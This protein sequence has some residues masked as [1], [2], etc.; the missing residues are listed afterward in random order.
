MKKFDE[1]I[2]L[3]N[4][5]L[6]KEI[7]NLRNMNTKLNAE[8]K[9]LK[10]ELQQS[11]AEIEQVKAYFM[12]SH[13]W[14][15]TAPLRGMRHYVRRGNIF[16]LLRFIYLH[17]PVNDQKKLWLKD[18]FYRKFGFL[19]KKQLR[20]RIWLAGNNGGDNA[21]SANFKLQRHFTGMMKGQ[22]G[23][24]AIHIHLY[25]TDLLEEFCDYLS[26]MPYKYD[27]LVSV[28]NKTPQQIDGLK[29]CFFRLSNVEKC[30]IRNLANQGRDVAPFFV[31]FKDLLLNYDYVAHIHTK[32]S[33]YTGSE[34]VEW[35]NYLLDQLIG[36]TENIEKIF[37]EFNINPDLGIV[38]PKPAP[39]VPYL[40]FTWLEN[41]ELGL[42]TLARLGIDS[43]KKTYFDYSAGTMF[44]ARPSALKKLINNLRQSDFPIEAG[45]TD[46][47]IAHVIERIICMVVNSEGMDYYETDFSTNSYTVN[48]GCKNLWQYLGKSMNDVKPYIDSHEFISFDIFDTLIM[49]NIAKP[50]FVNDIIERRIKNEL[51][52][53]IEFK[54]IRLLAEQN[55]R[56][57]HQGM[58]YDPSLTHIY[59]EFSRI[60]NFSVQIVN[61]LKKLELQVEMEL[62]IP[63]K[64]MVKWLD[65]AIEKK[66]KIFL[67]SDMYLEREN[68][69]ELLR[70]CGIKEIFNDDVQL[71]VSSE[72]GMRKDDKSVWNYLESMIDKQSLGHI[73]DNER[74]DWQIPIDMGFDSY[75][76]MSAYDAFSCC[77]FGQD[78]LDN[79][80]LTTFDAILL[81]P[82]LA[83]K[84]NSPFI[85]HDEQYF[86]KDFH[87]LGY[88]FYGP[89]LCIYILWLIKNFLSKDYQCIL[90]FARDGYFL[91]TL[92]KKVCKLLGLDE[93]NSKY[94]LTSRRAV[95]VA[96]FKSIEEVKELL[97]IPYSGSIKNFFFSRLGLVLEGEEYDRNI[98]LPM[99]KEYLWKLIQEKKSDI[100][101]IAGYERKNYIR[102]ITDEHIDLE[103]KIAVVDMGYAGTIQHY[104]TRLTEKDYDGYYFATNA[105]N[106]FHNRRIQG[107]FANNED[108]GTTKSSVFKYQ[109]IFES[110]LTSPDGQ[111]M[112][113]DDAGE[114]IYGEKGIGQKQI[115]SLVQVHNGVEQYC[116]DLINTYGK[117]I[118]DFQIDLHFIDTWTRTFVKN[119]QEYSDA[120]KEIYY[121]D[122]S[123]SNGLEDNIFNFYRSM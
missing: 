48:W 29:E 30:I 4:A 72:T 43:P 16:S 34:Q 46:G 122:D 108:Y 83:K 93:I 25:Y 31:G 56:K 40:A 13:S 58:R 36:S 120:I 103:K 107:C 114:P 81:G 37:W 84:Y 52:L 11:K 63:R 59:E 113:F 6:K 112:H 91:R 109:L 10:I 111:L 104:L 61:Q 95:S 49:R 47:T 116:E 123:Y 5:D 35:R 78:L 53:D 85:P 60:T 74:S 12:H 45:Q 88:V 73:G 117:M 69:F 105:K 44:W 80:N 7:Q 33:L 67:I 20:Y 118:L 102:Y 19:F 68:I 28:V 32:K 41:K 79:I 96:S 1:D 24:I 86:I 90:F 57:K 15:L 98:T 82:I 27:L 38:Y 66:K 18:T 99:G 9:Q 71:F 14:K 89:V 17:M 77:K 23:K 121:I 3:L 75:H 55:L 106:W 119:P 100:L 101:Y 70:K 26:H 50:Q 54:K 97:D 64:D 87:E 39:N 51:K 22:P 115:E 8:N 92:Y 94:F 76:I 21:V 110:I 65:Y 42:K 62:S 2:K